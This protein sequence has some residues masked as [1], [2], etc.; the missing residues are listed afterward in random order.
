MNKTDFFLIIALGVLFFCGCHSAMDKGRQSLEDT[1]KTARDY[2]FMTVYHTLSDDTSY[3]DST[4]LKFSVNE[5]ALVSGTYQWVLPGKDGRY[6]SV[7]GYFSHDTVYGRYHYQQ[8]GGSYNDSLQI[9]LKS[10]E[11]IAV[12]FSPDGYELRDTLTQK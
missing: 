2:N 3:A 12:Q 9:I 1:V 4:V 11:A 7:S 10:G 6:G 8:E 5:D